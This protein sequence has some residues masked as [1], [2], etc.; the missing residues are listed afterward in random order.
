MAQTLL[1]TTG[2]NDEQL[3]KEE[4]IYWRIQTY[5]LQIIRQYDKFLLKKE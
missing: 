4:K 2:H 1:G 5:F 3:F